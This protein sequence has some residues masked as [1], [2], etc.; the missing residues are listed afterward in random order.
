MH[1]AVRKTPGG[2]FGRVL[3]ALTGR[4]AAKQNSRCARRAEL[5]NYNKVRRSLKMEWPFFGVL[6]L[7]RFFSF[8]KRDGRWARHS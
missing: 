3:C 6:F 8:K 7:Q 5:S 4:D 2:Q 1:E